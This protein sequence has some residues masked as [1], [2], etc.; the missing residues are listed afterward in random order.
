M[1]RATHIETHLLLASAD[2]AD[3]EKSVNERCKEPFSPCKQVLFPMLEGNLDVKQDAIASPKTNVPVQYFF[4]EC[5]ATENFLRASRHG[6]M[7][8]EW[9]ARVCTAHREHA[10]AHRVI[11]QL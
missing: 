10:L 5:A 4:T 8:N 7:M 3:Y 6:N 1:K 11:P 2:T 9:T